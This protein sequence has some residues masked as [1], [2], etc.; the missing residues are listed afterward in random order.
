MIFL[1]PV[2]NMVHSFISND[3]RLFYILSFSF[4][5]VAK[6]NISAIIAFNSLLLLQ[7]RQQARSNWLAFDAINDQ[8][9]TI[10]GESSMHFFIGFVFFEELGLLLQTVIIIRIPYIVLQLLKSLALEWRRLFPFVNHGL[11]AYLIIHIT[12]PNFIAN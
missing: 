4:P 12:L 6:I 7:K 3:H 5:K 10:L 2:K 9:Q 11:V 1:L 8:C